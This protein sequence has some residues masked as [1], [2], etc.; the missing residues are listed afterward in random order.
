MLF[1]L[2]PVLPPSLR[3]LLEFNS[4]ILSSDLNQ[5][6]ER[7]ILCNRLLLDYTKSVYIDEIFL[8]NYKKKLQQSVDI[9][10]DKK[11]SKLNNNLKIHNNELKSLS[12]FLEGKYGRFRNNILGKRVDFSARSVIVVDPLL[13]LNQCGLPY[14]VTHELLSLSVVSLI[15]GKVNFIDIDNFSIKVIEEYIRKKDI[16]I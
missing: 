12:E 6:Y 9:L 14:E 5:L 4:K 11:K 15:I 16:Y 8:I 10:I 7:I 2:L 3:P 1:K 13:K